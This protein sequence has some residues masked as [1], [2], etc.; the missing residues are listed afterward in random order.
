MCA[1]VHWIPLRRLPEDKKAIR[2]LKR[3]ESDCFPE[4]NIKK[5]IEIS[6]KRILHIKFLHWCISRWENIKP[7]SE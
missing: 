7:F 1:Y 3:N 5:T 6:Y 2:N 4:A